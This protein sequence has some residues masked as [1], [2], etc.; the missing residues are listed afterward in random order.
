MS[1]SYTGADVPGTPV[2]E[3]RRLILLLVAINT[4][5]GLATL[6]WWTMMSL[7]V[8]EPIKWATW[9]GISSHP[10]FF[11]Y[12]FNMLWML[13]LGGA[14]ASWVLFKNGNRKHALWFGLFPVVFLGLVIGWFYLT[15][16]EW[17]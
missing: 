17:R 13:P 11:E 5:F 9:T 15:P 6:F 1:I 2:R 3:R 8:A 7:I 14:A 12:P 16:I 4:G 10:D